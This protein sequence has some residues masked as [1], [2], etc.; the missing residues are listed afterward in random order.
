MNLGDRFET[1]IT[2]TQA[3]VQAF[4]QLTGDTNPIHLDESYAANTAFKR[5]IIHGMLTASVFSKILGMDFPGEGT[6]YLKQSLVFK[7]PM[8]V[9]TPYQ[10]ICEVME[11]NERRGAATI[12]TQIFET[13]SEQ[14]VLQGEA[15][16]IN[17]KKIRKPKAST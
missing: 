6:I 14:L 8:F 9:N 1:N 10:V 13:D 12:S 16:I 2:Y 5:P 17:K 3:E 11:I 7:R 4:A 15:S